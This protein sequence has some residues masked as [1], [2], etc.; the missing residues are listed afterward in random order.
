[1]LCNYCKSCII[2]NSHLYAVHVKITISIEIVKTD[3]FIQKE[4]LA[5]CNILLS[6]HLHNSVSKQSTKNSQPDFLLLLV[7][8]ASIESVSGFTILSIC[9]CVLD[10]IYTF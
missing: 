2:K 5:Q 7:I 8:V 10:A 9:K 6:T 1:M 3:I 4:K